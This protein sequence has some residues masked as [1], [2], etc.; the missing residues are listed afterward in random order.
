MRCGFWQYP[1]RQGQP[2]QNTTAAS[3]PGKSLPLN[4]TNPPTR[5]P[6]ERRPGAAPPGG[7]PATA[8]G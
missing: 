6:V 4:G 3:L 7:S 1:Q 5:S 8:T 2:W